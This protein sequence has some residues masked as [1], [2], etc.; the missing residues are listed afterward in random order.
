MGSCVYVRIRIRQGSMT[1]ALIPKLMCKRYDM[2]LIWPLNNYLQECEK[3]LLPYS[4]VRVLEYSYSS[5]PIF[6]F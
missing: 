4:R 2:V 1:D 6:V 5:S 3:S